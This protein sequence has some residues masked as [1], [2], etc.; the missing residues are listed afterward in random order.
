MDDLIRARGAS[1][2]L[3]RAYPTEAEK[4]RKGV[5]VSKLVE[6]AE[7]GNRPAAAE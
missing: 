7:G 2:V 1:I 3:G 5:N 4:T 6:E